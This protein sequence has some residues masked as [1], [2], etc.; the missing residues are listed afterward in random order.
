[1]ATHRKPVLARI[2][3]L[4]LFLV[5][6]LIS[7]GIMAVYTSEYTSFSEPFFNTEKSH[8]KQIIWLGIS[9]FLGLIILFTDSKVFYS[10]SNLSYVF[11]IFLL[12]ITFVIGGEVKGSHSF[13]KFGSFTFQPGEMC[14][15]FTALA[16]SRFLSAPETRFNTLKDRLI[17]ATIVLIPCFL[18]I[19]QNETG[20]ALVY[21]AFFLPMYREGLPN[22]I[23]LVGLGSVALFLS[24]LLIERLPLFIAI[25]VIALLSV[26]ILWKQIKRQKLVILFIVGGWLIAVTFSQLVVPYIFKNVFKGYQ[27]ERIYSMLGQD[28]PLE[29]QK[30]GEA[31]KKDADYNVR[32]SKIAIGSGGVIGK[33]IMNG[34]QT[35]YSFVPEQHTDFVFCGI[36]EQFGFVGSALLVILYLSLLLRIVFL[37]ER[38]RSLFSRVY[39]Y[40]VASILFFHFAI[41]LS[42]TMG[43]APVIGI[44]LPM[45][46]Y[47]GTSLL[48]FSIL[49]F[50]MLRLDADRHILIR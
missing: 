16:L 22:S 11:G 26:W 7:I 34:T 47:G 27:V 50:I 17:A 1:M 48:S 3:W 24:S 42:M 15:I 10:L 19:L 23:L 33:G 14:K 31:A 13:I 8:M 38:Q 20:L 46:S 6:S 39:C 21:F 41:N 43:L 44:T 4:S 25:T 45:L 5:L 18:I 37:A 29:F 2:D 12:L 49:I 40:C 28:V 32:Q 36:G 9:C 35:K 30:P